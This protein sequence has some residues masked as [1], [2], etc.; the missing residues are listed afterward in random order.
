MHALRSEFRGTALG[1]VSEII[2]DQCEEVI[3]NWRVVFHG[4]WAALFASEAPESSGFGFGF[5]TARPLSQA[6][7]LPL[8]PSVGL[9]RVHARDAAGGERKVLRFCNKIASPEVELVKW[10]NR[11]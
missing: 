9:E 2:S 3:V 5:Y 10:L 11:I 8:D 6:L 4:V 1:S 7:P